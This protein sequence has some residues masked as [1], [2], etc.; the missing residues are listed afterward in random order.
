MHTLKKVYE[1]SYLTAENAERYR[2]IMRIFYRAEESS[3]F[4]LYAQDVYK[5]LK[6]QYE[7]FKDVSDTQVKAD[8]NQLVNW[9]NLMAEQDS[10]KVYTIEEYKNKQFR[11]SMSRVALEIER[12]MIRL[13]NLPLETTSLNNNFFLRIE[14]AIQNFP[15][16]LN[17]DYK[18]VNAWWKDLVEDFRR[19]NEKNQDYIRQFYT[20]KS[21]QLLKSMEF[22]LHKDELVQYLKDYIRELQIHSNVIA[23]LLHAISKEQ[24]DLFVKVYIQSER[25]IP[26]AEQGM[27]PQMYFEQIEQ[28]TKTTWSNIKNWFLSDEGESECSLI[29]NITNDIIQR[30][31]QNASMIVQMQNIGANR[32]VEYRRW[33]KMFLN[34]ESMQDAHELSTCLFG[35]MHMHHFKVNAS[36]ETDSIHSSSSEEI[37][38]TY[39]LSSHSRTYKPKVEKSVYSD[40]P[41][42]KQMRKDAYIEQMNQNR[43]EI[44]KYISHNILDVSTIQESVSPQTR[45]MILSW[46][47][48][49]NINVSKQAQNEFGWKYKVERLDGECE[50]HCEDGNLIMP[51]Y[52]LSFE[53]IL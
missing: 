12:M 46:I 30:V 26:N 13:E 23:G 52:I 9:N 7:E 25:M 53:E 32:K 11:Y 27:D 36:R 5:L 51:K 16:L 1:T 39:F 48:L 44:S 10:K 17:P 34:C 33:M 41:I 35:I 2:A 15:D 20:G 42:E 14:T 22:I 6:N 28:R 45:S 29:L 38:F 18:Q 4:Y 31:I 24:E 3:K 50:L 43:K 21:E 19:L 49:A 47:A 37:P 8:L 40:N